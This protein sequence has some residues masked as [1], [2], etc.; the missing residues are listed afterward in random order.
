MGI[1]RIA[2][3]AN[4][5]YATAWRVINNH[6]SASAEA[7]EAV[8]RA[9][10]EEG[11]EAP[12]AGAVVEGARRRGRPRKE[13]EGIRTRNVARIAVRNRTHISTTNG[14]PS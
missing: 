3:A 2:K 6:P 1:A 9:M 11:I 5:S 13:L 14:T 8:R 12:V 4:V 10:A 7:V